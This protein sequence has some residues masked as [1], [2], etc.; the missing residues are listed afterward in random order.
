MGHYRVES[1]ARR[2]VFYRALG[3][4][5]VEFL[6]FVCVLFL[7]ALCLHYNLHGVPAWVRHQHHPLYMLFG[8]TIS[9]SWVLYAVLASLHMGFC[10]LHRAM[11][12][13]GWAVCATLYFD[14]WIGLGAARLAVQLFYLAA[15]A[16]IILRVCYKMIWKKIWNAIRKK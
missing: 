2:R 14:Q 12:L 7:W 5:F 6:P 16:V 9:A 10:R 4:L 1:L 13:Y 11:I 8:A 15:G 3:R